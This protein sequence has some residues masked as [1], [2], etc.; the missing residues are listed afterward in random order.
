MTVKVS[1]GVPAA[2]QTTVRTVELWAHSSWD[3]TQLGRGR[4]RA[5]ER[6]AT[7]RSARSNCT[8]CPGTASIHKGT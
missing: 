4:M 7:R 8:R 6:G 1:C 5:R 3:R 2:R